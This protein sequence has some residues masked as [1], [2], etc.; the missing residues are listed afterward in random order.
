VV[1]G[2]YQEVIERLKFSQTLANPTLTQMAVAEFLSSGGY[3]KH[4]RRLR[5]TLAGRVERFRDV[6]ATEFPEGTR[7]TAPLGGFVLWV[8][9]PVGV[10]SLELQG[11]A[12]EQ[13]I[14][15][16]PGPIFSAR[17]RFH[18]FVRLSCGSFTPRTE[19]ALSLVAELACR[20][21]GRAPGARSRA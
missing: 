10:D 14:A 2:R 20:L 12:L 7:V 19:A 21:A 4:L 8:E 16:A 6:I 3:D 9:L 1:P 11:R 13:G 15:V 18:N 5:R 17:N